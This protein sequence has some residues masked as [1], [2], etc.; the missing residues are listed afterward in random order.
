MNA[1]TSFSEHPQWQFQSK[2]VQ[3]LFKLLCKDG[4]NEEFFH[5]VAFEHSMEKK[6]DL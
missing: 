4:Y 1:S 5:S 6:C 3:Q 2:S